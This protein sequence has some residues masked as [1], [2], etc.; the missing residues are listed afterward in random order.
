MIFFHYESMVPNHHH[1]PQ[2]VANL[3][4]REM[5]SRIYIGEHYVFLHT[6]IEAVGLMVLEIR[7]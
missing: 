7:R 2:A 4:P 3:D 6:N 1:D 5:L